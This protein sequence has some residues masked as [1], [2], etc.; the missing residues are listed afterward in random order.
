MVFIKNFNASALNAMRR[1]DAFY[2]PLPKCPIF[3]LGNIFDNAFED[4]N[5]MAIKR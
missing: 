5:I 3:V 4:R 2:F 1:A